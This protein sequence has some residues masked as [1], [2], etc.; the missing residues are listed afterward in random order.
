MKLN[1]RAA[2]PLLMGVAISYSACKKTENKP[3][4]TTTDN[5]A[6]SQASA[7][8]GKNLA[9][10]LVGA[11]GGASIKDGVNPSTTFKAASKTKVQSTDVG[12]GFYTD[13][14]LN[15]VWNQG[16][17][18]KAT[19][20]GGYSYYFVCNGAATIGYNLVDSIKTVGSG[21]GYSFV[22]NT[23]QKYT[24]RGLNTNNSNFS[25]NGTMQANADNNYT[26]PVS[27][28]SVHVTYTF[29]N[30]YVHGDDNFDITSG[31]ATFVSK[32]SFNGGGWEYSGTL[33]F[34]GNHKAQMVFLNHEYLVDL[35]TGATTPN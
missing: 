17:T 19:K 12:C 27:A 34:L 29:T 20:T 16:D 21:P 26:K 30:L 18:L 11:F 25:L 35:T 14:S 33:R 5:A 15:L 4:S 31:N 2:L 6:V 28:T 10:S 1:L 23:V 7:A 22:Y 13:N 8:I 24:V 32:G 9:Q 3:Q